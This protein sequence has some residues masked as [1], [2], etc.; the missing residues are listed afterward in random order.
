MERLD[1]APDFIGIGVQR[2]A[3]SWAYTLLNNH[4]Q[5]YM[6]RKEMH[7]FDHDTENTVAWYRAQFDKADSF[8]LRGEFTPDYISSGVAM[9]RLAQ[10]CPHTKIIIF[11]REQM[12]RTFSAYQLFR[13][14]GYFKNMGYKEALLKDKTLVEKSLYTSQLEIVFELFPRANVFICLQ[15]E[16]KSDPF[17]VYRNI[18]E[19]LGINEVGPIVAIQEVKNSTAFASVQGT[20]GLQRINDLLR[21]PV[22][23]PIKRSKL[24]KSTKRYIVARHKEQSR[25]EYPDTN[26]LMRF[27]E[28]TEKTEKLLDTPL[29]RWKHEQLAAMAAVDGVS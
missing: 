1:L 13:S 6:P 4:P 22:F 9:R 23:R 12:E 2:A 17:M 27:L 25:F 10:H 26:V 19:F 15:D 11:L 24:Y 21:I 5:V 7:Y 8:Q 20:F 29:S 18:C 28:D 3:T 14:H 16:V